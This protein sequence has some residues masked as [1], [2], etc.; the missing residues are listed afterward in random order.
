MSAAA[1]EARTAPA[2]RAA[3]RARVRGRRHV[4]GGVA[5]IVVFG[6]LLAGVVA[7]NVA[8]L[9]SNI[10]LD[11]LGQ[12]RTNLR[13]EIATLQSQVS[14]AAAGPRIAGLAARQLGLQQADADHTTYAEIAP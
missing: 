8:V 4:S 7:I 6:V 1:A 13:A 11:K 2:R 10:R 14:S 9:Q 12:Q 5:W 3:P